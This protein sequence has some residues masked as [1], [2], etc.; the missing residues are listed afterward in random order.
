ME[1]IYHEAFITHMHILYFTIYAMCYTGGSIPMIYPFS[2]NPSLLQ[3]N[4][5]GGMR[6]HVICVKACARSV[7][8]RSVQVDMQPCG[9]GTKYTHQVGSWQKPFFMFLIGLI[10]K[11]LPKS[12]NVG[13]RIVLVNVVTCLCKLTGMCWNVVISGKLR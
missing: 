10:L 13:T 1:H 11:L 4:C 8:K 9:Y 12:H 7:V 2:L 3:I 6:V 5:V